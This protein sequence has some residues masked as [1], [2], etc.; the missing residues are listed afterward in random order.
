MRRPQHDLPPL[1][2]NRALLRACW[3]RGWAGFTFMKHS[4]PWPA[5]VLLLIVLH[6]AFTAASMSAKAGS[7]LGAAMVALTF[8]LGVVVWLYW[9]EMQ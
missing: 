9:R 1:T 3:A 7:G 2:T 4:T 6:Y 8:T 5:L